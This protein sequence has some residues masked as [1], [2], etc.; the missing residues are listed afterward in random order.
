MPAT[1]A[2][3]PVNLH[4]LYVDHR[5]WLH[6]W[7]CRRLGCSH[8][9]ADL[10]QDTYLRLL[11]SNQ[12]PSQEQ[13]KPYLMQIAKGLVIDRYRRRQI[14]KAW[15]E[16]LSLQADATAPSPE[17]TALALEALIRIDQMLSGLKPKVRETFLLSRFDGLTYS[18]IAKRL[19]IST[20]AVRKYM[21]IAMQACMAA[22][23][24]G[25]DSSND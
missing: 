11:A 9:A 2:A 5:G 25:Y 13:A 22:S 24:D 20:A 18:A 8:R 17:E 3:P 4:D 19:Q 21:L 12:S 14:E 23:T 16:T 15:L 6:N 7:L 10:V 1:D